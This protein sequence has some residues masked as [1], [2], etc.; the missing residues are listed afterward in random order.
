MT[1]CLKSLHHCLECW[2][3]TSLCQ[4]HLVKTILSK[5]VSTHFSGIDFSWSFRAKIWWICQNSFLHYMNWCISA[6]TKLFLPKKRCLKSLKDNFL[7]NECH[8]YGFLIG[9][10]WTITIGPSLNNMMPKVSSRLPQHLQT[11][12][13]QPVSSVELEDPLSS[14]LSRIGKGTRKQH[15]DRSLLKA[16][17]LTLNSGFISKL[18]NYIKTQNKVEKDYEKAFIGIIPWYIIVFMKDLLWPQ[19]FSI[20][21]FDNCR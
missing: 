12:V 8:G 14:S 19:T 2:L 7:W 18:F 15:D 1:L 21:V 20:Q 4:K 3:R 11:L 9:P 13:Y 6:L 10:D 5:L 16:V 17:A